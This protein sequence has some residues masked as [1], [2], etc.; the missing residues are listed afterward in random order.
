MFSMRQPITSSYACHQVMTAT[1]AVIAIDTPL[2]A[3]DR[4]STFA[5]PP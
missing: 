4:Y 2:K 5:L 1:L 3:R